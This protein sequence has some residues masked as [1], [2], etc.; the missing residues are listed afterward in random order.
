MER[1][2]SH[3]VR[4]Q[5][6]RYIVG[7][8]PDDETTLLLKKRFAAAWLRNP[9][10]AFAAAREIE[11]DEPGRQYWISNNWVTDP[12]VI[13]ER[14]RMFAQGGALSRVPTREDLALEVYNHKCK[15]DSTQLQYYKFF[16]DLMGYIKKDENGGNT[17]NINLLNAPG[18]R[19]MPVPIAAS[20]EEWERCATSHAQ[21]LLSRHA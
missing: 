6:A 18:A 5:L 2:N 14:D 17:T 11:P 19:I 21:M 13:A 1:G 3:L 9:D 8:Y 12:E 7:M 4:R 10:N 20:D 15:D 16:A